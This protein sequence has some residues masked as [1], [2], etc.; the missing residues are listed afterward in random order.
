[1]E[2]AEK[3]TY[4]LCFRLV[5]Y[6][7]DKKPVDILSEGA[8]YLDDLVSQYSRSKAQLRLCSF[9]LD[10]DNHLTKTKMLIEPLRTVDLTREQLL[11]LAYSI[12]H[13]TGVS[14]RAIQV[15]NRKIIQVELETK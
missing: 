4:E 13:V 5:A 15:G 1:M 3:L 12:G 11:Q 7:S 2:R 14:V 8:I 6:D 9:L 10:A